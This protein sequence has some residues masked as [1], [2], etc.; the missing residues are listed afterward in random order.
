MKLRY[1]AI[2][3]AI[4]LLIL[5]GCAKQAPTAPTA[6]AAPVAPTAPAAP[7]GE[8][9]APS[10]GAEGAEGEEQVVEVPTTEPGPGLVTSDQLD[11][12]EYVQTGMMGEPQNK[13]QAL[14][15]DFTA[16]PVRF[17]NFDCVKDETTG[18][19]YISIKVTNTNTVRPFLISKIGVAKGYDTYFMVRGLVDEDPGCA[20]EELAA[21][22]STVCDKIGKDDLRYGNPAGVNKLNIQSPGDDGKKMT[23]S[24]VVNC[25]E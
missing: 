24:V 18:I 11:T 9:A 12:G 23:E 8:Q 13:D 7:G 6:P 4:T 20:V 19:N 25:P 14:A 10:E 5:A 16:E 17:S 1:L 3:F 21:G 22:E 2:A 15:R